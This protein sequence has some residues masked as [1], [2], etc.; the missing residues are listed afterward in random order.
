MMW[1]GQLSIPG[2]AIDSLFCDN[3]FSGSMTRAVHRSLGDGNEHIKNG[4]AICDLCDL[5]LRSLRS[6]SLRSL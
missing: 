3:S 2:I 1:G 5:F 4:V 6:R